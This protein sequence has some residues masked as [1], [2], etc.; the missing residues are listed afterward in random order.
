[1]KNLSFRIA[2]AVPVFCALL[3]MTACDGMPANTAFNTNS[4]NF[5]NSSRNINMLP[6]PAGNSSNSANTAADTNVSTANTANTANIS[7]G[8]ASGNLNNINKTNTPS[9]TPQNTEQNDSDKK[10]EGMF[11]FPP[12]RATTFLVKDVVAD[13][14]GEQISL[15]QYMSKIREALSRA[16]Y[17]DDRMVYFSHKREFALVTALER[18]DENG[19]PLEPKRWSE[20]IPTAGGLG[21]YFNYLF[22]GKKILYRFTAFVVSEDGINPRR[23]QPPEF[24]SAKKWIEKGEIST[25]KI[26]VGTQTAQTFMLDKNYKCYVLIYNFERHIGSGTEVF[27]YDFIPAKDQLEATKIVF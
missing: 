1:M 19:K 9:P 14:P 13:G 26:N 15:N 3:L 2:A 17:G 22:Y 21:E 23:G 5:A 8:N 16:G 11:S 24:Q 20:A 12:P 6:S 25:D 10:D 4:G 27:L 18:I 7:T